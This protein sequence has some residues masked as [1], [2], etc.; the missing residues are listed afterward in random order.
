MTRND[1]ITLIS[2][3]CGCTR[4]NAAEAVD[5]LFDMM[6]IELGIG[7]EVPLPSI[8]R[9]SRI[10]TKGGEGRNPRTGEKIDIAPGYRVKL[11][12]GLVMKARLAQAAQAP[13]RAAE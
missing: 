9:L 10:P 7:G 13:A 11:S 2:Q 5:D 12:V 3:R 1:M 8:G 6:A 4:R